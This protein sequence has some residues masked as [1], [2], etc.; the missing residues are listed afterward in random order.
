MDIAKKTPVWIVARAIANGELNIRKYFDEHGITCFVPTKTTLL[1]RKGEMVEQEVPIIR[2]MLFF[3]ADFATAQTLF[4]L[5]AGRL[6]RVRDTKGLLTVPDRQMEAF[7]RFIEENYGKVQILDTHY[8]VGDKMMIKKGPLAGMVG[9]VTKID[10]KNYFTINLEGLLVAAV[11][12]PKSN[13]V[14]VEEAE[15]K[16]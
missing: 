13:L 4:N 3:K 9:K 7:I 2:N 16:P 6:F 10:N 1:K 15:K 14:K 5:N 11:K 12:F 8:V